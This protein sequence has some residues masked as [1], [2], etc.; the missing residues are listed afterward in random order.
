[1]TILA[2][3]MNFD[4]FEEIHDFYRLYLNYLKINLNYDRNYLLTNRKIDITIMFSNLRH[5]MISIW[6]I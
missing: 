6:L 5:I 1:M 3:D 2:M 4:S